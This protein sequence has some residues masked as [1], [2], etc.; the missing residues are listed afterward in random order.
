MSSAPSAQPGARSFFEELKRRRVVRAA[1]AYIAGVIALLQGAQPVFQGLLL[2]D[3]AFRALVIMT[4][5]GFPVVIVLAW[6]YELTA[7]GLR[8]TPAAPSPAPAGRV[9]LARWIRVAGVFVLASVVAA[10]TAAGLGRWRYPAEAADGRV[11]LAVFPFRASAAD[12]SV[13]SEGAA[14]LLA[15]AL[16]GTAGLRIVDPWTL[17]R[18]LRPGRNARAEAP[19]PEQAASLAQRA[20]A[21]RFLLGSVVATGDRA[22]LSLRLYQVGRA[23]PISTFAVSEA[24]DRVVEA[25]RSVAVRVLA[26]VW[27]A[28]R[29]PELPGELDF[30]AT[31]SLDALKA[32]LAAKE[33]MRRGQIDSA[34]IAIDEA[35]GHDSTF[36]LALV[37][38]VTIKSWGFSMRGQPY[39]GFFELLERTE[40]LAVSL[41]PRT[42][43]RLEAMRASIRTDGTNAYAAARRILEID[44][45]DLEAR[46]SLSYFERAY[47]WQ[48]GLTFGAAREAIEESI[49]LDSTYLPNLT[50]RA[51]IAVSLGDSADQ[52]QQLRRL[53]LADTSGTLGQG[54]MHALRA[55]L[56]SDSVFQVMASELAQLPSVERIMVLR[57]L[58]ASSIART[59]T[60]L[61]AMRQSIDP[62]TVATATF[63]QARLEIARGHADRVDS[64]IAGRA[65]AA[66]N[67]FATLHMTIL[68]A[69]LAGI[70]DSPVT[71]RIAAIVSAYLPPPESARAYLQTRPVWQGGWLIGAYH[72]MHGDTTIARR[73]ID[74]L[75]TLPRGGT[76][77][78][79]NAALQ[80]DIS[81]RLASRRGDLETALREARRAR[82]LWY[83]HADNNPEIAPSPSI[84]LHLAMLQ[85]QA[86]QPDSARALFESLVPPTTWVGF[87]TARASFELGAIEGERGNG[88]LAAFHYRR[89]LQLWEGAGPGAATWLQQTRG[90]LDRLI[91]R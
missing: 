33:A 4:V 37:E 67:A 71:E 22:E 51:W 75:G 9:P 63:E 76:P 10:G 89:A 45:S 80:S 5:A 56:S 58:R 84:R 57:A 35:L 69:S 38:A 2:P 7:H 50:S 78:D 40:P 82:E 79:Y 66:D 70:T 34:N 6:I 39:A 27:G 88:P 52:R 23:E 48:F 65:Y 1:L 18:P 55:T 73:W 86:G 85:R 12:E 87:L 36:V 60:L 72:A 42:R 24:A 59:R 19:E 25:V 83:I 14:D 11:G 91:N 81:A 20:G 68:A 44:P 90:A 29:P 8:R 53:A 15:T 49:R 28:R 16:D 54:W 31:P 32:Y 47:G 13:W 64:A 77:E 46:T 21:H 74:A 3:I 61:D 26:R 41:N 43:L 30:D 17:W 62:G